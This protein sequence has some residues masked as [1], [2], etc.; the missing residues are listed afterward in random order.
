MA[1]LDDP[2]TASDNRWMHRPHFDWDA[3]RAAEEGDGP[4]AAVL[5][6]VRRLA[7]T[8]AVLPPRLGL[9]EVEETTDRGVLAYLRRTP[10]S[11]L[12]VAVNL[13]DSDGSVEVP[14]G[15]WRDLELGSALE[16]GEVAL[17]PYEYRILLDSE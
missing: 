13:A 8:R 3:L 7:E 1:F 11:R 5:A 12:F 4:A 2:H 17:E 14:E 6:G 15:T 16:P 9:P 10:D